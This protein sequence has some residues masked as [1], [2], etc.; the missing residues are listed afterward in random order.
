MG[1]TS[2]SPLFG[3]ENAG[4]YVAGETVAV[5]GPGPI[6]LMAIQLVRHPPQALRRR[7]PRAEV[8]VS[9]IGAVGSPGTSG[10]PG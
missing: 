4:G 2:G 10:A 7:S 6:G 3:L 9:P 1:M 8:T 5:L